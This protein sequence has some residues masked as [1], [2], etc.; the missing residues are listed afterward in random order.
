MHLV[1]L[2]DIPWYSY[3]FLWVWCKCLAFLMNT[4]VLPCFSHNITRENMVISWNF[5]SNSAVK[6]VSVSSILLKTLHFNN[7]LLA[8]YKLLP[9]FLFL[10]FFL[11]LT[12]KEDFFIIL[13]VNSVTYYQHCYSILVIEFDSNR[14]EQDLWTHIII[15]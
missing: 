3:M 7:S 6:T 9:F 4:M 2:Y 5:F 10:T 8:K 15:R 12:K 13:F 14:I 11:L 1:R